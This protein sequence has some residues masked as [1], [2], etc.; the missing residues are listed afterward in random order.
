MD[1]R[2]DWLLPNKGDPE[3][4]IC[5]TQA[6]IL[7]R[8]IL[9]SVPDGEVIVVVECEENLVLPVQ[10]QAS[11]RG[12]QMIFEA[13]LGDIVGSSGAKVVVYPGEVT[14]P[15][16]LCS[17]HDRITRTLPAIA[18]VAQGAMVLDDT[19]FAD[20]SIESMHRVLRPKV[21][22]SLNLD[23]LFSAPTTQPQP[24]L[25]FFIFYSSS[26]CVTGNI[27]QSNYVAAN[28]F[29]ASLAA[30]RRSRGLAGSVVHIGAIM[31]VGYVTRETSEALQVNL[32]KNG[33]T[34]MSEGDFHGIFAEGIVAGYPAPAADGLQDTSSKSK[35]ESHSSAASSGWESGEVITGLRQ[36]EASD[37]SRPLWTFNPQF[38]HLVRESSS[39]P[40][41][42]AEGAAAAGSP[43]NQRVSL[44]ARLAEITS[45]EDL[46]DVVR[47]AFISKLH[48]MLGSSSTGTSRSPADIA[49][50]MHTP[51]E[52]LGIDS[53]NI[54]DI[55][56][57]FLKELHAD[58][59]V[60]R[61]LGGATI[62][63]I[64]RFAVGKVPGELV[65]GLVAGEG[66]G[67]SNGVNGVNGLTQTAD[68]GLGGNALDRPVA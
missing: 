60:L 31:G 61:I 52:Q 36:Y 5:H 7:S 58:I 2:T 34:W 17:V 67:K 28:M 48:V 55:R 24:P 23:A 9:D 41:L 14:N 25:D 56:S 59:P 44:R 32:L 18:G 63:D 3:V 21:L 19:I 64:V 40:G 30:S 38:A 39:G 12:I 1:I 47:D 65:P 46:H 42:G 6:I 45:A 10:Q 33:N 37:E 29:M 35:S 66:E 4:A 22:G 15:S 50:M 26:T 13:V 54:V 20:M 53:L 11:H 62:G 8:G 49:S 57:W 27:G 16:S 43:T 68:A 51:A